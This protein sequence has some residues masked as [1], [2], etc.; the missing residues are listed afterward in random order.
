MTMPE[1]SDFE[2]GD[3]LPEFDE[4]AFEYVPQN[5][6]MKSTIWKKEAEILGGI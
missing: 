5:N 6:V 3:E 1:S 2:S 4:N